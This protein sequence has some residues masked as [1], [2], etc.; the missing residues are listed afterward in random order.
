MVGTLAAIKAK[1]GCAHAVGS[2]ESIVS[3]CLPC[4]ANT[5]TTKYN[6]LQP[7]EM[8]PHV[9]HEIGI[10]HSS[11]S[12]SGTYG[13]VIVCERS[14]MAI[15]EHTNTHIRDSHK[16][17]KKGLQNIW[18][19]LRTKIQRNE[20]QTQKNNATMAPRQKLTSHVTPRDSTPKHRSCA[21]GSNEQRVQ[22]KQPQNERNGI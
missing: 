20:L 8:S 2:T 10:D 18:R 12:P 9:W 15:V 1:D 22:W 11:K 7:S 3:Q 16:S 19:T 17:P 14:R 5:D 4:L 13:L 6:P 21:Q